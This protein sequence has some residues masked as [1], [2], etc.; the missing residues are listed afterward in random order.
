MVI[1][2]DAEKA[3]DSVSHEYLRKFLQIYNF[4][5]T[6]ISF[7]SL[8][9]NNNSAVVQVKGHLSSSFV[10]ERGVKQGD[11][12]SCSLFVLAMDPLIRNIEV[13]TCIEPL[14]LVNGNNQSKIKTL[15]YADDIAVVTKNVDSVNEIFREYERLFSCSGLKLNADKTE[16]LKL[17]N[18]SISDATIRVRYLN[19]DVHLSTTDR[20]KIT[21]NHLLL[22][23]EERYALNVTSRINSSCKVLELVFLDVN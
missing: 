23:R 21:G 4:P 16:I 11:A 8:I 13:N 17:S 19:D 22:D 3:F 12:L 20:I 2:F 5:E 7:F 14:L 15:A 1:S 18:N 9:Y 10:V 6:F